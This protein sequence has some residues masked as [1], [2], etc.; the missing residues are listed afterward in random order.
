MTDFTFKLRIDSRNSLK[1]VSPSSSP[2]PSPPPSSSPFPPSPPSPPPPPPPRVSRPLPRH[3]SL[4]SYAP[5]PAPT[6]SLRSRS[7]S[8]NGRSE[9]DR[10][11]SVACVEDVGM[12]ELLG[13]PTW[14]AS[15]QSIIYIYYLNE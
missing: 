5:F 13:G 8:R 7:R 15:M 1:L 3:P 10:G 14:M 4:L 11:E 6:A 2:S 12:W 9:A